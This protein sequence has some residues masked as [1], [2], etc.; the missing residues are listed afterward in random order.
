MSESKIRSN[1]PGGANNQAK[2]DRIPDGQVRELLNVDALPDGSLRL[3]P[4]YEQRVARQ[5]RGAVV[6]GAGFLAAADNQLVQYRGETDSAHDLATIDA[7]G[8]FAGAVL[9]DT[10]YVCT[11]TH[12]LC[13]QG[14]VAYPWTA[15][16]VGVA[17]T[18]VDDANFTPG[19][20]LAAV[21]LVDVRGVEHGCV[22]SCFDVPKGKA[23]R[24]LFSVP[25]GYVARLYQT[26]AND[27]VLF[28]QKVV[29]GPVTLAATLDNSV[30]LL[31]TNLLAPPPCPI[32]KAYKSRLVLANG[33][34]LYVTEPFAPHLHHRIRG[35]TQY[36]S[37]IVDVAPTDGGVYVLS[38]RVWFV[39]GL[40]T[41]QVQ[42]RVV[43]EFGAVAGSATLLPDGRATWFSKYGQVYGDAAGAI[44]LPNRT[45]YAPVLAERASVG[46][47]ELEGNRTVVT[48]LRGQTADNSLGLRDHFDV[49]IE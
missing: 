34:T 38:D 40:G 14:Q 17:V 8:F 25:A 41:E 3:R 6:Y 46:V 5:L 10:A 37:T 29:T 49:E 43:T 30:R 4:G 35:C 11:P 1:W 39:T 33:T 12:Q 44:E 2:A 48:T 31:T 24:L 42:Q 20:Y 47:V 23:P 27:D 36:G 15:P 16:E 32:V 22:P 13:V 9:N 18:L 19:R 28:F 7:S 26:V 21:V 45:S